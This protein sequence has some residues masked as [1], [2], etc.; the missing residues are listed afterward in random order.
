MAEQLHS[1][2]RVNA[3]TLTRM[4]LRMNFVGMSE[5]LHVT[6]HSSPSPPNARCDHDASY[7]PCQLEPPIRFDVL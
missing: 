1:G 2:Q 5:L 3:S 7:I 4:T 6:E